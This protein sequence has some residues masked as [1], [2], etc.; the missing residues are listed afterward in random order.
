MVSDVML[1]FVGPTAIQPR[2]WLAFCA[3]FGRD[4][5]FCLKFAFVSKFLYSAPV[6]L[7]YIIF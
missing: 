7:I 2:T 6:N 5:N 3:C 1:N 4:R